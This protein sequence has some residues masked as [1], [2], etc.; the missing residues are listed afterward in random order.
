MVIPP[1]S[2]T[3]RPASSTAQRE[4]VLSAPAN[5][6]SSNAERRVPQTGSPP[7]QGTFR[8]VIGHDIYFR[9][10]GCGSEPVLIGPLRV[11]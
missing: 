4:G 8:R 2:I 3:V 9:S 11:R 10:T 1:E 5:S 7:D 6:R